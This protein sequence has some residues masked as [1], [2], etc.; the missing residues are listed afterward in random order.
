[1][2]MMFLFGVMVGAF[3]AGIG[4]AAFVWRSAGNYHGGQRAR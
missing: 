1:M 2:P 4:F 3:A